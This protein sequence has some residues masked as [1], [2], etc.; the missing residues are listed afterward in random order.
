MS[1]PSIAEVTTERLELWIDR[2]AYLLRT[3]QI[4]EHELE[5][6]QSLY[7]KLMREY[8]KRRLPSEMFEKLENYESLSPEDQQDFLVKM[9]GIITDRMEGTEK[10]LDEY[11]P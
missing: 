6:R 4:P 10:P 1:V 11:F 2:L 3:N 5:A 8:N 7:S 9:H